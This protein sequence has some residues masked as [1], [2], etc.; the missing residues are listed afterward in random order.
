MTLPAY[1]M[2][3]QISLASTSNQIVIRNFLQANFDNQLPGVILNGILLCE[4]HNIKSSLH[5]NISLPQLHANEKLCMVLNVLRTSW[6]E[7]Q[8]TTY[9]LHQK[10]TLLPTTMD[11]KQARNIIFFHLQQYQ[12]FQLKNTNAI[13]KMKYLGLFTLNGLLRLKFLLRLGATAAFL[14]ASVASGKWF[15]WKFDLFRARAPCQKI[16]TKIIEGVI[17][18]GFPLPQTKL[19]F[20]KKLY[21]YIKDKK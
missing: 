4:H 12:C 8:M 7:E 2:A 3:E 15:P 21:L 13:Y 14:A 19:R 9:Y 18:Q 17:F 6:S 10:K 1:S 20:I 5:P 16:K 11:S